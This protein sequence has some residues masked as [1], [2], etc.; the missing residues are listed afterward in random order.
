MEN[1]DNFNKKAKTTVSELIDLRKD[2]NDYNIS[3]KII[4]TK[5]KNKIKKLDQIIFS[6]C[7]HNYGPIET[8]YEPCGRFPRYQYCENC[9]H[10]KEL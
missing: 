6:L 5:I 8:M 1:K 2:F 4:E 7:E 10:C 3:I 9:N